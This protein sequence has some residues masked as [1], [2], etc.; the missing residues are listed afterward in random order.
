MAGSLSPES[1]KFIESELGRAKNEV[2]DTIEG[3]EIIS[4]HPACV[5]V[6][7]TKTKYKT[8]TVQLQ[9]TDGYPNTAILTELKSSILPPRLLSKLTELC[10][11]EMKKH[12]GK[13][14][15]LI[16]LR[17]VR[18]FLDDNPLIV[19]SDELSYIKTKLV[20]DEVDQLK[21]KQKAGVLSLHIQR[22]RYQMD[23]RLSVPDNYP[24]DS[25]RV[26][27]KDSN[28]PVS[29]ERVFIGQATDMARQA[30][31]PPVRQNPKHPPF[32]PKPS[33]RLVCD[34]LVK[35]C[36]RRYPTE[37]CSL[38]TKPALPPEPKDCV[39]DPD[40]ALYVERVY[41]AHV[42]HYGC[43][44]KYMKTPPFTGGKKCPACG[45]VIYHDR[46]KV[47]PKLAEQRWAH[48]E[49]KNRELTEVQD[50]LNDCI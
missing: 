40:D 9:F 22:L 6:R 26:E 33:L 35:D 15:V 50:F 43:L 27:L 16:I 14:Q 5:Q 20:S 28:F 48:K 49:A 24:A 3:A 11:S 38:C 8:L 47:T 1:L 36:I 10:D 13:Q 41:C 45:K 31:E 2:T 39:S 25:V 46:W 34:F 12:V 32:Q 21:V 7:I 29:L 30:V 44:D 42:F 17:F 19:C 37:P 23:F 4:F 18:K